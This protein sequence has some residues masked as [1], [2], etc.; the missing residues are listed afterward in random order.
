LRVE[1]EKTIEL[2]KE[3][4]EQS[5]NQL[6]KEAQRTQKREK[7]QKEKDLAALTTK[8]EENQDDKVIL[9]LTKNALPQV[10]AHPCTLHVQFHILWT[11]FLG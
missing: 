4:E 11:Y 3:K 6:E 8:M 2:E 10:L 9:L 1:I 5:R 7:K